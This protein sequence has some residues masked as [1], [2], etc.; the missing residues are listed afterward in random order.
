MYSW[1]DCEPDDLYKQ[2]T[3]SLYEWQDTLPHPLP[4]YLDY[5]R[6]RGPGMQYVSPW[7]SSIGQ[8]TFIARPM[9]VRHG[10]PTDVT[11]C[12]RGS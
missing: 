5:W 6:Q 3:Y 11:G 10:K 1:L 4:D 7:L 2:A 12:E 8:F 9:Q